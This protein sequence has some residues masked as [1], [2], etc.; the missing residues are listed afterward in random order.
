MHISVLSIN[1]R[2]RTPLVPEDIEGMEVSLALLSISMGSDS[3]RYS[4]RLVL[5]GVLGI[6]L[7]ASEPGAGDWGLGGMLALL[8]RLSNAFVGSTGGVQEVSLVTL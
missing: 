6:G 8:I 2:K 4:S 1:K 7:G 3:F 5:E